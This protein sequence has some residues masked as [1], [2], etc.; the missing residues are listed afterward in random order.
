MNIFRFIIFI[1]TVPTLLCCKSPEPPD[2]NPD[3][4]PSDSLQLSLADQIQTYPQT[5]GNRTLSGKGNILGKSPLKIDLG[6]TP[7]WLLGAPYERG[8]YGFV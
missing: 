6:K 5:N 2:I 1:L 8:V 7:A 4:Q 3:P